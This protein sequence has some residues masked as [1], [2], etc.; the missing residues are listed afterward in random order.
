MDILILILLVVAAVCFLLAAIGFGT[1]VKDLIGLGLFF[2]VLT[3]I[4]RALETV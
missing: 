3:A 1:R 4:L 2:W